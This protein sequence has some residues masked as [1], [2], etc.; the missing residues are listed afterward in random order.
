MKIRFSCTFKLFDTFNR[1][2]DTFFLSA[3]EKYMEGERGPQVFP[4][5]HKKERLRS[6]EL[7]N[8]Q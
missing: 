2:F 8:K 5:F 7:K 6:S 1:L 3:K 4:V